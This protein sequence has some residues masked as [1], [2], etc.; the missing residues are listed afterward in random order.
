MPTKIELY[1]STFFGVS[2]AELRKPGLTVVPHAGLKGYRGAWIFVRERCIILSVPPESV[3]EIVQKV[4]KVGINWESALHLEI[5]Q[6]LFGRRIVKHIG[7]V[8]Q[9]YYD[10]SNLPVAPSEQ[11][12]QIQHG[13]DLV[14]LHKLSDSGDPNGWRDSGLEATQHQAYGY[15]HQGT[16]VA[17]A[18]YKLML[19]QAGFIGVFTHPGYRG[20]GFGQAVVKAV[21]AKL[22]S[23][24]L[25]VLYQTLMSN[26]SSIGLAQ[27]VGIREYAQ[28]IAV[29]LK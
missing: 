29:R 27:Q 10:R 7:P 21:V 2:P 12:R 6:K 25:L 16:L 22:L 5:P 3:N 1:W 11:I 13:Q 4:G 23:K 26:Q 24:D 28:N 20:Q 15:W 14:A 18:N 8:F 17:A 19:G 9:G